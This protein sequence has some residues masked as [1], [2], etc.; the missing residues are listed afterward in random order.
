MRSPRAS[1]H[2]IGSLASAAWIGLVPAA[3]LAQT[4]LQWSQ[5]AGSEPVEE[6][7]IYAGATVALGVMVYSGLPAPQA[8]VYS[9][10]V[11]LD[12]V[13][14]GGPVYVWVTASNSAGESA[15]SNA[16]VV[17]AT[18]PPAPPAAPDPVCDPLDSDCD[19]IL[20]GDDNCPYAA[21]PGQEDR[22]G[23]GSLATPDGIGDACQCGDVSGDGK[24]TSADS[25]MI[26]GALKVPP[27]AVMTHPEL[28]DV[29]GATGCTGGDATI[30][31]RALQTPPRATISQVCAPDQPLAP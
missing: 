14:T 8:G 28:C 25:A 15:P 1:S 23:L 29:G 9:A 5:P 31:K 24:I 26:S 4:S 21:N 10:D 13:D 17:A 30:I 27:R 6:Y 19:G 16:F 7:R 20:D 18:A 2:W 12:A 22:G 3:A 11:S